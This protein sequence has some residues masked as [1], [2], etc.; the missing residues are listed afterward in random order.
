MMEELH[1]EAAIVIVPV[2][3]KEQ[4]HIVALLR[5]LR[6]S[7]FP[8]TEP[9]LIFSLFRSSARPPSCFLSLR[10]PREPIPSGEDVQSRHRTTAG[11]YCSRELSY[12]SPILFALLDHANVAD[13]VL[14]VLSAQC[15]L[16]ISGARSNALQRHRS[17]STTGDPGKVAL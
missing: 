8:T 7:H 9:L 2:P 6:W 5:G 11:D 13:P 14:G 12:P 15:P 17:Q 4:R 16:L 3:G 1:P 10:G